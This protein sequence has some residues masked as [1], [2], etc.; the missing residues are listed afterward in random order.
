[1][2][3]PVIGADGPS[4]CDPQKWLVGVSWRHQK[5]FRHFVGDEEQHERE[6]EESQVINRVN[7]A[8][9]SVRYNLNA[10]WS[11][12]AS[13]P[14]LMATRSSPIRDEN[15]EVVARS[16]SR[17]AGIGDIMLVARRWMFDPEMQDSHNLSLGFGVKLPTG[18][19]GQ[20]GTRTRL[21]DGTFVTSV[22]TV[23]QSIQP[24]DG[25]F[26]FLVD[27][28]GFQRIGGRAAVYASGSYLSNPQGTNGVQTFRSRE[29]EATMSVADQYVARVGA[30][31][32][33]PGLSSMAAS[34]G[35]RA[36]GVPAHDLF[37]PSNGFRRPGYAYSVEPS[38]SYRVGSTTLTAAAPVAVYRNRTISVPD[39]QRDGHGDAAFADWVL[40]V[41]ATRTL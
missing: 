36:E 11:A 6:L 29:S 34:L 8:D 24:G 18:D 15:R 30:S 37:G 2:D 10:R 12:A 21:E 14:Y 17:G 20:V 23:D 3:A 7:L 32:V 16:I 26:G 39:E 25:G 19:A 5:S 13:V 38:L 28:M 33:V 35:F 41:G 40:M 9:V 22:Q 4:G 27:L 1:M 31:A